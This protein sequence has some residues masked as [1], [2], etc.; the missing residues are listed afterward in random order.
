MFEEEDGDDKSIAI[1]IGDDEDNAYN[2]QGQVPWADAEIFDDTNFL[3]PS[4]KPYTG[5]KNVL[6][7]N[8]P[9]MIM[10]DEERTVR[11]KISFLQWNMWTI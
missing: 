6:K 4:A 7:S 9:L 3:V 8:H 1:S 10:A 11:K 2:N 5:S